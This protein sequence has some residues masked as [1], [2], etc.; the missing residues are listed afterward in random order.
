M[1]RSRAESRDVVAR[2]LEIAFTRDSEWPLDPGGLAAL[3]DM[4]FSERRIADYFDVSPDDV[5]VLRD[6][7]GI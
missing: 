4:G 2:S 5:Q 7:Y 1:N 6:E 3:I